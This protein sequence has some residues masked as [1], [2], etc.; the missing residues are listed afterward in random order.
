M[1]ALESRHQR[2]ERLVMGR[3]GAYQEPQSLRS[4]TICCLVKCVVGLQELDG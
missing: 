3:E 4:M 1:P 2:D